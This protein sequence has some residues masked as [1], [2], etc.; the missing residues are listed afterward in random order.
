MVCQAATSQGSL[1]G[2]HVDVDYGG[3]KAAAHSADFT[4][5]N[6]A[7]VMSLASVIAA[8]RCSAKALTDLIMIEPAKESS[9]CAPTDYNAAM[10]AFAL[11]PCDLVCVLH[12][13]PVSF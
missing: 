10:L 6:E 9:Q 1:L 8:V 11:R 3:G 12:V 2:M 7:E 5:A 13:S 4:F